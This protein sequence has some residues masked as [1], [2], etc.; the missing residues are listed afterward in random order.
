MLLQGEW[1]C[2]AQLP[3]LKPPPP[4]KIGCLIDFPRGIFGHELHR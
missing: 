2:A 3:A 4:A 1:E